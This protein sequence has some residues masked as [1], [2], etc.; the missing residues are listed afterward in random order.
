[1]RPAM[2]SEKKI[3]TASRKK[4]SAST[5]DAIVDAASG[6]SGVPVHMRLEP[7]APGLGARGQP[8]ASNHDEDERAEGEHRRDPGEAQ[9]PHDDEAVA[10]AHRVVV[11]AV[12]QQRI[13]DVADLAVR[14]L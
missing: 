12:E 11:I 9:R 7:R 3:A 6:K 10:P 5:R 4:Y 2:R 14:G 8:F 13:G 1:M